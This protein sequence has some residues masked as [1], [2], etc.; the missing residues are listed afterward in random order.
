MKTSDDQPPVLSI[1]DLCQKFRVHMGH[2]RHVGMLSAVLFK[3]T[4]SLHGLDE[5]YESLIYHAG[6]LHNV[7]FADGR[8]GHHTRGRDILFNTPLTD[9]PDPDRAILA[10]TTLWH[11]KR[12]KPERLEEPAYLALPPADQSVARWLAAL[13]RIADGLDYSHSHAT[14]IRDIN[15][16]PKGVTITVRGPYADV[17]A[18]RADGKAD[19]WRDV[20]GIGMRVGA[21]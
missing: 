8:K 14:T 19:L 18:A 10:V 11:R 12:W 15:I 2:A 4:R 16:K 20:I 17:D 5:R 1:S 3:E 6:I 21:R 7:A 9:L 13:L